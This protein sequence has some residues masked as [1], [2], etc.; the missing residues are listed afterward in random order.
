MERVKIQSDQVFDYRRAGERG[1]LGGKPTGP[2][3][4]ITKRSRRILGRIHRCVW[5]AVSPVF[6][7]PGA[8]HSSP[9]PRYLLPW[10]PFPSINCQ[11][12]PPSSEIPGLKPSFPHWQDYW[13]R[14]FYSAL[15][16]ES[17]SLFVALVPERGTFALKTQAVPAW[18]LW[19]NGS[20]PFFRNQPVRENTKKLLTAVAPRSYQSN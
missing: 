9:Y 5:Q 8:F 11:L 19:A 13:Q 1:S 2:D 12:L 17:H 10:P 7:L 4:S 6:I 16:N 18:V 15:S 14:C 20:G 3:K